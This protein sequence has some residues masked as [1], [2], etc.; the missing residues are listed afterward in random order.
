M[1]DFRTAILAASLT[2]SAAILALMVAGSIA[3]A[4]G[5][6]TRLTSVDKSAFA[7]FVGT[8]GSKSGK[9]LSFVKAPISFPM[10]GIVTGNQ[11]RKVRGLAATAKR[12]EVR[13]RFGSDGHWYSQVFDNEDGTVTVAGDRAVA[14]SSG[15]PLDRLIQS[16]GEPAT[17][18]NPDITFQG[19]DIE[20]PQAD[21]VAATFTLGGPVYMVTL[22]CFKERRWKC[23]E[24]VGGAE[25]IRKLVESLNLLSEGDGQ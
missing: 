14:Q 11:F 6:E 12:T 25:T 5:V 20:G 18:E 17:I 3:I 4:A 8:A 19:S 24:D 2:A 13:Y 22:A 21:E 16:Q 10:L 23:R 15:T 9:A 1:I 7:R